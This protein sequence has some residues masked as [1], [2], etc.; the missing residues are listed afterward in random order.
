MTTTMTDALPVIPDEPPSD[1]AHVWIDDDGLLRRGRQW[2]ALPDTEWRLM[3]PLVDRM[4]RLVRREDLAAA[5]WPG[6]AV[7]EG[8][9]NVRMN[10]LRRR[11]APLGLD[12]TTVRGRG[13]VLG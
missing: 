13:Y 11:L 10:G 6:R 5:G 12:I 1:D 8:L 7:S 3:Q 9:L 4:G 2:V